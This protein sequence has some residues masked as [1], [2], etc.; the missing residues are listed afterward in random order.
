MPLVDDQPVGQLLV[1]GACR[2]GGDEGLGGAV[3]VPGAD[4][5]A[6]AVRELWAG[7]AVADRAELPSAFGGVLVEAAQ[8]EVG[9]AGPLD[10]G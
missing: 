6:Q 10:Q 8:G 7:G 4:L 9:Q 3:A 1:W 2:V 5:L